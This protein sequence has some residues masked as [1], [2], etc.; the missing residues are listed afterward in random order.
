M[1]IKWFEEKQYQVSIQS[2]D[3]VLVTTVIFSFILTQTPCRIFFLISG[4]PSL[5]LRQLLNGGY[6]VYQK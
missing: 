3:T 2:K 6:T 1:N 5:S 4:I